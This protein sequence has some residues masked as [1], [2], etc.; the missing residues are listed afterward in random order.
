M[1]RPQAARRLF[2]VVCLLWAGHAIAGSD[3]D[4]AEWL[5]RMSTAM[6]QMS[7]QGT[8]VYVQGDDVV[9]M[10]ITHVA[11]EAGVRERLVSVS[12]VPREVIRDSTGVRWV[13]GDDRSV[14]QDQ[15]FNR[16]FFPQLPLDQQGQ[17]RRS[18]ALKLGDVGRVAGQTARNLSILPRDEYRYGYSLWLEEHSAM[19]L[20]WELID[21]RR[22]PLAKLMFTDIRMGAEVDR[23]ELQPSSELK[24]FKTVESSLPAGRGLAS[25]QPRWRPGRLP[26]GFELTA[27]RFFGQQ[28]D[29]IYEHLVYSDGL[30]AVSVY[31]ESAAEGEQ[32]PA[33]LRR[34][35]TT[36]AFSKTADGVAITVIGDVPSITV[37]LIGETVSPVSQ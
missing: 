16:T 27:H 8:F 13:L 2:A 21:H 35:G 15:G 29:S 7:Y 34:M 11:G 32:Q 26:P 6:S 3:E 14:L 5:E 20:K 36:H 9:T 18:Y 12:G 19:L 31:I 1:M 30:T 4:P 22:K 25:A 33:D 24:K 17:A 23:F 10:R 28:Q 37:K